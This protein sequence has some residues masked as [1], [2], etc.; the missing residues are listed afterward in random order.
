VE[1]EKP[2]G[3]A[4]VYDVIPFAPPVSVNRF[5]TQTGLLLDAVAVGNVFTTT[6]VVAVL[7]HVPFETVTV[8]VPA[9]A[10]VELAETMGLCDVLEYPP[11]PAHVY[12]VIP[13]APPVNVNGLPIHTGKLLDAVAVGSV[14]TTTVVVAV[15]VHVPFVTVTV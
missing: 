13:F 8:Y 4:H 15:L 6:V 1:P 5:P 9:M 2:L 12:E 10:D 7:M 3:P 11:G 14:F